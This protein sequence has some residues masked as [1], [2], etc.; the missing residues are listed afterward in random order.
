MHIR[1]LVLL[2]FLANK[3]G[4]PYGDELCLILPE[5]RSS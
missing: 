5:S 1:N 4:A 3:I 2:F